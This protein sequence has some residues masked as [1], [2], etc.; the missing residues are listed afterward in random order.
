MK[1]LCLLVALSLAPFSASAEVMHYSLCTLNDG[2]AATDVQAWV[3]SWRQLVKQS[4]KKYE[5]RI[6]VPHA[7]PEKANQ[8][9][10]EGSSPT[11][12]THADAWE[13]WYSDA[14]AQK[15]NAQL[16]SVASCGEASIYRTTD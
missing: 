13:W 5:V 12:S 6:L 8:F 4:G 7:S 9:F 10:L 16:V 3:T 15:S 1:K 14:Q 2:K 11:L